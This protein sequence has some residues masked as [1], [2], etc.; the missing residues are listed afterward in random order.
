MIFVTVGTHEQ[1]F[2]RLIE[3]IDQLK[4]ECIIT[5]EVFI[6]TGF[7]TYVPQFCDWKSLLTY[8]EMEY[9]MSLANI[10][11]TH[12]GPATFMGAIAKGK[13]TIVVPRQKKYG[14]HVNDHQMEFVEYAKKIYGNI[15]I[16]NDISDIATQLEYNVDLKSLVVSNNEQFNR[17]L[18]KE[19]EKLVK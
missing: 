1:Q 5:D 17:L 14:E 6:Q 11:I 4:K 16:I 13:K 2:N 9:Y 8:S 7:S 10:V 12:G 18:R 3:E 19:I 15:V